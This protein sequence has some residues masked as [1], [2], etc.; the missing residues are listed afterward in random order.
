MSSEISHEHL[1][2]KFQD[3]IVLGG[4]N[5]ANCHF[6]CSICGWIMPPPPLSLGAEAWGIAVK[7]SGQSHALT[8]LIEHIQQEAISGDQRASRIPIDEMTDSN[9]PKCG[10]HK[11]E[12]GFTET[13]H[14]GAVQ[15]MSCNTC[16]ARWKNIYDFSA[17]YLIDE[18]VDGVIVDIPRT[19][20]TTSGS[21]LSEEIDALRITNED[22][23]HE[24]EVVYGQKAELERQINESQLSY[25]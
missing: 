23:R 3:R 17:V 21:E 25:Q 2:Q 18:G 16:N 12:G 11:V 1:L 14:D 6:Y 15:E 7:A 10:S 24:L 19:G 8:H 4:E 22:L 20:T 5:T 13:G 9:C